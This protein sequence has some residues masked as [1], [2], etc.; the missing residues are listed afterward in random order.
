MTKTPDYMVI[1]HARSLH[2]GV[3]DSGAD[4]FEAATFQVFAHGF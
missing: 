3:A 2:V 1:H 4:E